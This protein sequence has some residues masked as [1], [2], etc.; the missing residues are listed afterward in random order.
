MKE[1]MFLVNTYTYLGLFILFFFSVSYKDVIFMVNFSKEALISSR[2]IKK[3]REYLINVTL[4]FFSLSVG[5][6]A[7]NDSLFYFN[8]LNSLYLS[9]MIIKYMGCH[10]EVK[11]AS[12]ISNEIIKGKNPSIF[13]SEYYISFAVLLSLYNFYQIYMIKNT[14]SILFDKVLYLIPVSLFFLNL[15]IFASIKLIN[16]GS[17]FNIKEV[18]GHITNSLCILSYI[19]SFMIIFYTDFIVKEFN[20][21][22]IINSSTIIISGIIYF[23]Y[24]HKYIKDLNK[25]FNF[26]VANGMITNGKVVEIN[27]KGTK[28]F[29]NFK[30]KKSYLLLIGFIVYITL[31][32]FL[33]H[34]FL[35]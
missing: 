32:I 29:I 18:K 16:N 33:L 28:L 13:L 5:F 9:I 1:Y 19:L 31:Y 25:P 34:S 24:Y 11:K 23:I 20:L 35:Q 26:N 17:D 21:T 12:L 10:K 27:L 30:N 15:L 4:I 8:L 14:E 6:G 3:F 2:T 22:G 7:Y